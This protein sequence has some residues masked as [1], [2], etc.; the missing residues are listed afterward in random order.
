M[1][2]TVRSIEICYDIAAIPDVDVDAPAVLTKALDFRNDV[3]HHIEAVL[4]KDTPYAGIR[5]ITRQEFDPS[6]FEA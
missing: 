6:G 2:D 3:M 5:E 4:V 1:P